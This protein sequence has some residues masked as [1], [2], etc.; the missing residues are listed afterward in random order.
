MRAV[1]DALR[2]FAGDEVDVLSGPQAETTWLEEGIDG[3]LRRRLA[4]PVT[5]IFVKGDERAGARHDEP[6]GRKAGP[7]AL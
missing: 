5:Q 2:V 6:R 4:I 7:L 3:N 1:E